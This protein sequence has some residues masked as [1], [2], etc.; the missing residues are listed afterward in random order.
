MKLGVKTSKEVIKKRL[1]LVNERVVVG[2]K[3]LQKSR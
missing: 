2:I 3:T 1:K